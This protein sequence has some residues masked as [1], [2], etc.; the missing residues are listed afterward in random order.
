M[1]TRSTVEELLRARGLFVRC[2]SCQEE[3]P[4]RQA[5]LFDL[6]RPLPDYALAHLNEQSAD[7][8]EQVEDLRRE[9]RELKRRSFTSAATSG[10]GQVL[11]MLTPSIRGLP[12]ALQDC[13]PLFTPIDYVAFEGA[14]QGK[15]EAITF[16]E[17]KTGEGRLTPVQR[18]I[19]AAVTAGQVRFRIADH[20]LPAPEGES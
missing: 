6:T 5:R 4:V 1:G 17:V 19:S 11:E 15:V 2:P 12:I 7:L 9:R 18:Q 13:R 14:A 10:L 8:A 16:I 20:L 3:F